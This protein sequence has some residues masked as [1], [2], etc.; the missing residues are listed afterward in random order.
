[1]AARRDLWSILAVAAV[2]VAALALP[3]WKP[4]PRAERSLA[5]EPRFAPATPATIG[6]KTD[7]ADRVPTGSPF[8]LPWSGWKA[9]LL[10]V[11]EKINDNRLLAVAAGVVFY[12][13]LALFPALAAFVS[14]YGLVSD[15]SSV[16]SHLALVSGILPAGA[17][18]VLHE[19]LARL[20]A[21]RSSTLSIGLA[22]STLIALWSANAGVKSILDALNVANDRKETRSFVRLNLVA[23]VFTIG[24]VIAVILAVSA[25]VVAPLVFEALGLVGVGDRLV[26]AARWPALLAMVVLGLAVLYRYGPAPGALRCRW[27]SVGA[28]AAAFA[29]L[30]ASAGLSWYIANF[31]NY[32]ATYGSLGAGIGMMTWMWVSMIV[33][34]VGAELNVEI[35][36]WLARGP[37]GLERSASSR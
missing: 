26:Q 3:Q 15:P 4:Q 31:G 11:Y 8:R 32:D 25:V 35:D 17:V 20:T 19:E 30:A 34:L 29:W 22:A 14:I 28:V 1:M 9:V 16:D 6:P 13:L 2:G 27:L 5:R 7:A 10:G 12:C 33:V 21:N 18:S 37:D 23:F 24:G 36:R